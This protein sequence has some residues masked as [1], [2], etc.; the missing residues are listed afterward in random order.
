M[1]LRLICGKA[2]T[3]KSDFCL[4]EVKKKINDNKKIY[5]ITPEQYSFTEERKLLCKLENGSTMNAEVLTF[6]RMAYRV[7]NEVGGVNKTSLS[8]SGKAMLIYDILDRKKKELNFLG[9]T[10]QN[11]ELV[12]TMITEL[13]K[14]SVS[15]N[16]L[17]KLD[18]E[19]IYLKKKLEDV[20]LI[21]REFDKLLEGR[22]IEENDRLKILEMQLDKT[23]MFK[24]CIIY[25]DEF[26]G[27]TKQEFQ[28]IKKLMKIADSV[29]I[30][31][32]TDNLDMGQDISQDLFY[33][34]KQTADKLLYIARTNDIKCDK[35]VFLDTA[36]RFENE[37]LAH[38]ES[39]LEK[40]PF[41]QY[42]NDVENISITLIQNPYSEVENVAKKII[43]L[44]KKGYR[45][46]DIAIITKQ[47]DVYGSLSKAIFNE[48]QIP[49]F[50]DEK[51]E[52][53]QNLFAKY[54][55]ALLEIYSSGWSYESVITYL[56]SGFIDIEDEV[57]YEI[58]NYAKKF[59]IKGSKWYQDEWKYGEDDEKVK[60]LNQ[61]K[62]DIFI[63]LVILKEKFS[64]EKTVESMNTALFEFL[65]EN[66]LEEKLKNKQEILEEKGE[67]EL[68]KE[69]EVAWNIVV[70]ILEEMTDLFGN[71]KVS[72]N[73]YR[74]LLKIAL[75]ENG[76]GA[77]PQTQDEVIV[78]DATRTKI[79]E[80]K[81]IFILGVNDGQ[82]PSIRKDEG[83]LNDS[84]REF[85]KE[86]DIELAK[87]TL[88]NLYEERF[89][90][91]KVLTTARE[92]VF[93]S[94][95]SSDS[96]GG[97]LRPSIYITKLKKIFPK[98]IEIS[99][100]NDEKFE[101]INEANTFD[102]LINNLREE[103]EGKDIE[104]IWH[105]IEK[106]F[107]ESSKWKVKL[108]QAKKALIYKEQTD[109]ISEENIKKMYGNT[110]ETSVSKLE[111]YQKCA[112]SYFLKYGLKLKEQEEYK[113]RT[114]DTGTFMHETIDTFF[115]ILREKNLEIGEME[116]E[117]IYEIIEQIIN[118]KLGLSKYYVFTSN[119]KFNVL[120][121]KLKKV[122]F[123]SMKYLIEGLRASDF[124]VYANELEFKKGKECR[125]ITLDL[126]DGRKVEITGKIDRV[127]VAK[128][129]NNKYVRII[130]YKSSVKSIDLNELVA[131]MQIQLITYLDATCKIDNM[132]PA[133]MLYYNLIEPVLKEDKPVSKEKIENDLK[134][135]FKMNGLILA[136]VNI[137][138]LMDKNL[139]SGSSKLVPALI[140][141]DGSISEKKS[142][143]ADGI[144]FKNLMKHSNKIIKE[145]SKE[146]M[147]G[148]I[149]I[150]PYCQRKIKKTACDYCEYSGICNFKESNLSFKYIDNDKKED[151]L[152]RFKEE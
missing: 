11:I 131:G 31:I 42:K 110:L 79:Q 3:G 99:D 105:Y 118:E 59:G 104:P 8:K 151:I 117:Q 23:E 124:K 58:E 54:L 83:F 25:I 127:D 96:E 84:D 89:S 111:Q 133:G 37:E 13:K 63:P 9:K 121:N 50:I 14:H 55:L 24:D 102:Q 67:L 22:Y 94:Y 36:Y 16:N 74:E 28:I 122:V 149:E 30:T 71:R 137:I 51:K 34:N 132:L 32:T 1:S 141:Q 44:V 18:T 103:K 2:G 56:K 125:P 29:N 26:T 139:V 140:K 93:I 101:I 136:D 61:V 120:T 40:V 17:E 41:N 60:Y 144:Q 100:M 88:E 126:E 142:S 20:I 68:S 15:L 109:D 78:G 143:V 106:Y 138:K 145:I 87:G 75:N 76:L 98:I 95:C 92:R 113:I 152:A 6:A 150:K 134:N 69:Q 123:Q 73:N 148:N 5:I 82:F 119:E 10:K 107:E 38:L 52:L 135:K 48:Y 12:E 115:H 33:S 90:I 49:F 72:F 46:R 66:K 128:Y 116:D 85:F 47:L 77:I 53:N 86:N 129:G 97:A 64:E 91:Y 112:F 130:D 80:V 147:N 114:I 108:E 19:N 62:N 45:Y 43:K 65:I 81:A 7:L 35:T 4:E 57:I 70:Q 146:I 39:N 21:Y 27:F